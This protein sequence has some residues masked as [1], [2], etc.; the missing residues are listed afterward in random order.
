MKTSN[1]FLAKKHL[2]TDAPAQKHKKQSIRHPMIRL[3]DTL[4][5]SYSWFTGSYGRL[6]LVII[7]EQNYFRERFNT[8]R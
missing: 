6:T 8:Q 7:N 5:N 4:F 2:I 1:P 3:A